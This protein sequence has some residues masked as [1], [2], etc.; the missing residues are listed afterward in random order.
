MSSKYPTGT[1]NGV[2]NSVA[3]RTTNM[4]RTAGQ[5]Q[6]TSTTGPLPQH[7]AVIMDGNGRWA[8]K[9]NLPRIEGHSQ[10][11]ASVR[12]VTEHAARRGIEQLTLYCLSSENWQR[13]QAELDFLMLLLEQY[14]VEERSLLMRERIRLIMIGSR[15]GLPSSTLAAIDETVGMC[16]KNDGMRLCLAV[17]YG[18]RAEIVKAA[19]TLAHQVASG[20]LHP[21]EID[22]SSIESQ[23]E[24]NGMPDPDLLIRTAGEMRISNFLLWQMSY[25]EF[26][27][28]PDLWPDFTERHLDLA[29]TAF[30]SRERR[31]GGLAS[32]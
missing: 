31:F 13:P 5:Q 32:S 29:I 15:D 19:K 12:K 1:S 8:E 24:T 6:T 7:V 3:T 26:W 17:N 11:V 28:T 10:G 25:A 14:M 23:L 20:R 16:C 27:V 21:D 4:S 18:G 9:R 30:Q 2:N 22:E